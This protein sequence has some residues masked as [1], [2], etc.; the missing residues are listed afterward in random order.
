MQLIPKVCMHIVNFVAAQSG[1]TRRA[2][3]CSHN[4]GTGAHC[5]DCVS[6][7]PQQWIG[8]SRIRVSCAEWLTRETR[9]EWLSRTTRRIITIVHFACFSLHHPGHNPTLVC[10]RAH[11]GELCASSDIALA[12]ILCELL[13]YYTLKCCSRSGELGTRQA[14][15]F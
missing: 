7:L 14:I 1:E 2:R 12:F 5:A 9:P 6:A 13:Y 10:R 15:Y 4:P 11:A 3:L 8:M